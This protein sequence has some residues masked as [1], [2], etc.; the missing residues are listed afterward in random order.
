MTP[1][2]MTASD[3]VASGVKLST[4]YSSRTQFLFQYLQF[5]NTSP[6]PQ[7]KSS[8]YLTL[9]DLLVLENALALF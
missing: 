1:E 7:K 3:T 8:F 2:M 9:S 6:H 5:S 4:A